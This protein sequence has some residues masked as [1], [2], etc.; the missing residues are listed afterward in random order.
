MRTQCADVQ[1]LW[2]IAEIT[3]GYTLRSIAVD[4]VKFIH[5]IAKNITTMKTPVGQVPLCGSR[6]QSAPVPVCC[7]AGRAQPSEEQWKGAAEWEGSGLSFAPTVLAFLKLDSR[8]GTYTKL[9][10]HVRA[11]QMLFV[12]PRG[13]LASCLKD[14]ENLSKG[15]D[16]FGFSMWTI[17]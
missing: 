9:H 16:P 1:H 14:R 13:V 10:S 12:F 11:S 7:A 5:A 17:L 15:N 2:A 6:G 4:A 8:V 3:V